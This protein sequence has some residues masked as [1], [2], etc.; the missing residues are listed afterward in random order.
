MAARCVDLWGVGWAA[1]LAA[2]RLGRGEPG[3]N[4]PHTQVAVPCTGTSLPWSPLAVPSRHRPVTSFAH[5]QVA[6]VHADTGTIRHTR[7]N[8]AD[9]VLGWPEN[10]TRSRRA[11]L[12]YRA[13][14][15][16]R[17]CAVGEPVARVGDAVSLCAHW[18][19][20]CGPPGL[21]ST[22]PRWKRR[23]RDSWPAASRAARPPV[24]TYAARQL[25]ERPGQ[26]G[27]VRGTDPRP[28]AGT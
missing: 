3:P 20:F 17:W 10:E 11:A 13:R 9:F 19:S 23:G 6:G 1:F 27:E 5:S 26:G 8:H 28:R 12:T 14:W 4:A 24:R 2:V 7:T 21:P 25:H 15:A 22:F 18:P 16:S